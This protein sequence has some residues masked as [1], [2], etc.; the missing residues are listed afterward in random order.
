MKFPHRH[1]FT[2][3]AL[4]LLPACG[5]MDIT[6]STDRHPVVDHGVSA[7]ILMPNQQAPG[8][9]TLPG[10]PGYGAQGAAGQPGA[11]GAPGAYGQPGAWVPPQ[12]QPQKHYQSFGGAS[13]NDTGQ[14]TNKSSPSAMKY[15]GAPIA[16]AT[17]PFKKLYDKMKPDPAPL[18]PAQAAAAA[19]MQRGGTPPPAGAPVYPPTRE[20]MQAANESARLSELERQLAMVNSAPPPGVAPAPGTPSP[21]PSAQPGSSL[22]IAEELAALRSTRTGRAPEPGPTAAP[23]PV[24]AIPRATPEPKGVADHMEDRSGDGTPDYWAYREGDHLVREV[25]DDDG[26]GRPDKTMYYDDAGELSRVEEDVDHDGSLDAW[27][28]YR[29]GDVVRRRADSDHDGAVDS[30]SFYHGGQIA[31]TERDTDGDGFRDRLDIYDAGKL[32]REEED[33]NADGRPDRVTWYDA[34]GE[35]NRRDDD[36]DGDGAVD[37]RSVYEGG[38]LARRELLSD[39]AL[40]E[41][42]EAG[43]PAVDDDEAVSSPDTFQE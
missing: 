35:M 3:A 31:R 42:N 25:F 37:V 13:V 43:L 21:V 22:S 26:D 5:H 8:M 11:A 27:A 32:V 39:E 7:T 41:L 10:Y 20:G 6:Q 36:S 9:S 12:A 29:D 38:R 4:A 18:D 24:P 2:I 16:I 1:L 19:G 15:I 17:A 33:R 30:W 40:A 23:F 28:L 34:A 14:T